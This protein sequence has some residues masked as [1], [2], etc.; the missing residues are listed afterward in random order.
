MSDVVYVAVGRGGR[1]ARMVYH[2][3]RE[4]FAR[5][6]VSRRVATLVSEAEAA[7]LEPCQFCGDA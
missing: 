1:H 7:G 3:T 6:G 4:C 5:H 2:F